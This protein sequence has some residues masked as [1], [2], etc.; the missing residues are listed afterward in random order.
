MSK[1]WVDLDIMSDD[2]YQIAA[3]RLDNGIMG[4]LKGS[5]LRRAENVIDIYKFSG[6]NYPSVYGEIE[7]DE[8][9][10]TPMDNALQIEG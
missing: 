5:A 7:I 8:Y 1:I 10:F 9:D 4:K 6:T 3:H 2:N